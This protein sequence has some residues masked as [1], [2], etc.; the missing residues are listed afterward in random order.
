MIQPGDC[1][2]LTAIARELG[3]RAPSRAMHAVPGQ[4]STGNACRRHPRARIRPP[5]WWEPN[6]QEGPRAP[7]Q[8]T[9]P[10][11][12]APVSAGKKRIRT[13]IPG[14]ARGR[15]HVR[16]VSAALRRGAA[17]PAHAARRRS[18]E[19]DRCD[20]L[21]YHAVN[22]FPTYRCGAAD[23]QLVGRA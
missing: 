21:C 3:I 1:R 15:Q 2:D 19:R 23:A 5:S 10:T 6:R 13:P 4:A 9:H 22:A 16:Q 18:G 7:S 17:Q 12:I 20:F 11:V 8:G 14:R